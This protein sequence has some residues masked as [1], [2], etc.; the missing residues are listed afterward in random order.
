MESVVNKKAYF[1][2]EILE[3]Y[4]VGI[5]LTGPEVK[6][7][8]RGQVDLSNS[9]VHIDQTMTPWLTNAHIAAYQPAWQVQQNYDPNRPRK[10]LLKKNELLKL[11]PQIK[12]RGLTIVP[13]KVY[14]KGGLVKLQIG[15]ARGKKKYDRREAVKRRETERSIKQAFKS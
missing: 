10:L 6:S 4:D 8:K 12:E 5:I 3:T 1:D 7:A 14:T 11:T 9:Y 15:L 13:L 2:Y